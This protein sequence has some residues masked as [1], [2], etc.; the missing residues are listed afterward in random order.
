MTGAAQ[1]GVN[2]MYD[3]THVAD[4]MIPDMLTANHC[5]SLVPH[6]RFLSR[7]KS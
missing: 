6:A 5:Y 3:S 1:R 4:G 2:K 7:E